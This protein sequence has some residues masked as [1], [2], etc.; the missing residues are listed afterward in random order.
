[1]RE[2]VA[3]RIE[4]QSSNRGNGDLFKGKSGPKSKC[5]KFQSSNRGNGDLF[6][7]VEPIE[8]FDIESFN[9]LIEAMGIHS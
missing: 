7:L 4:F 3:L 5:K 2:F 9:P 1:M 8:E 6:K